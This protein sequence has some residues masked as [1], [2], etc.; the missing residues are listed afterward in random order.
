M[1]RGGSRKG[2]RRGGAKGGER[3][4]GRPPGTGGPNFTPKLGVHGR[5][6]GVA[7]AMTI[8]REEK[9]RALVGAIDLLP[10]DVMLS[11][12]RYFSEV[13]DQYRSVMNANLGQ[14][15]AVA[16][17]RAAAEQ[18]ERAA[19]DAELTFRRYLM[20]ACDIAY[21]VAPYCHARLMG[22]VNDPTANMAGTGFDM[23][24]GILNE[25]AE[26]S[27][28]SMLIEHQP[29]EQTMAEADR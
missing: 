26:H 3:S 22:M 7:S 20:D 19:A 5:K 1:P 12:M 11:A 2:E 21:K 13:A 24:R 29:E 10:K 27:R 15:A 18:Y 23:L 4:I 6:R 16:A 28:G 14:A 8:E 9:M 25:I 17:D